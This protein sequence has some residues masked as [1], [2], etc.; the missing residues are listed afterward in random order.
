[1]YSESYEEYIRNILGYPANRNIYDNNDNMQFLDN[2]NYNN[3]MFDDTDEL[4]QYYPD[5]YNNIYPK[6][7]ESCLKNTNPINAT[8][9][10]NMV[11][12]IY[13]SLEVNQ[14]NRTN[15][16]ITNNSRNSNTS[17]SK[18]E[19]RSSLVENRQRPN[20]NFLRDLIRILLLREL[21]RR[22]GRPPR[23]RPPLVPGPRPPFN[24][25]PRPPFR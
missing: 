18:T 3:N 5:I 24:P 13:N 25:Q 15:A 21:T 8:L 2:Q 20:N 14:E 6:I 12:E 19:N 17:V 1:M 10:D 11:E 9:L 7:R 23:P 16:S 4:E 22:P